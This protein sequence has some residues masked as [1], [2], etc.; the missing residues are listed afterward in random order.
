MNSIV[1]DSILF[2]GARVEN[3]VLADSYVGANAQVSP[4]VRTL[5]VGD[6]SLLG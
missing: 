4:F 1:R 2:V 5:N 6:H 3:V